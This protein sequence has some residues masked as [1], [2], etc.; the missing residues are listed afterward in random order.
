MSNGGRGAF[1]TNL[2][3]AAGGACFNPADPAGNTFFPAIGY[4]PVNPTAKYVVTGPGAASNVG[5]NS[6]YS[7]GFRVLNLSLAK[8]VHFTESRYLQLRVDAFNILNHPNFALSN[9]NVF[10]NA[11]VTAATSTHGYVF[12]T[13]P[14]FLNAP[15]WFTGGIRS[16]TLG[17]KFIF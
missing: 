9:G 17:A 13:D 16:L 12:P 11:G 8:N 6:F 2:G 10:S 7:P 14:N 3:V 15:A 1:G 5:R 4:T